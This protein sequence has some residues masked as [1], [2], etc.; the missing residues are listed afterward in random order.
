MSFCQVCEL[1]RISGQ[2]WGL[3]LGGGLIVGVVVVGVA[4][5]D[6]YLIVMSGGY[7]HDDC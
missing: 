4:G 6:W 2:G 5:V 7:S 3:G 1:K